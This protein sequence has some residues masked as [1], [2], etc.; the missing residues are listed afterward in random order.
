[1]AAQSTPP[2]NAEIVRKIAELALR[3]A[4]E[5]TVLIGLMRGLQAVSPVSGHWTPT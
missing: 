1:M 3:H 2:S 4:I 5:I